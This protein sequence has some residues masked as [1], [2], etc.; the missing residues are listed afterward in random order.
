MTK[1]ELLEQAKTLG[2]TPVTRNSVA[3]LEAMIATAT[4]KPKAPRKAKGKKATGDNPGVVRLIEA[5][6]TGDF[7]LALE[8]ADLT[9]GGLARRLDVEP[10]VVAKI[11]S[12]KRT[13]RTTSPADSIAGKLAAWFVGTVKAAKRA[14]KAAA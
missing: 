1:K 10:A 12:G 3:E 7:D 6:G 2:L 13:P 14:G 8:A 9:P 4:A 5:I 11:V